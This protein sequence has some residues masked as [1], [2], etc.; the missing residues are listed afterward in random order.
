MRTQFVDTQKNREIQYKKAVSFKKAFRRFEDVKAE[1][2]R[3]QWTEEKEVFHY[4]KI[5]LLATFI[6][7]MLLYIAD[8]IAQ[9]GL[10]GISFLLKMILG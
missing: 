4:T 3:I 8:V 2:F 6:S 10:S 9:Q 7:G 5:V 1:F